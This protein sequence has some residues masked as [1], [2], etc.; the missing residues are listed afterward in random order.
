MQEGSAIF[1]GLLLIDAAHALIDS[2]LCK[3]TYSVT[4]P[5]HD[6]QAPTKVGVVSLVQTHIRR[7]ET[8]INLETKRCLK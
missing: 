5:N 4:R 1:V 8:L 6:N 2:S 7:K 3:R